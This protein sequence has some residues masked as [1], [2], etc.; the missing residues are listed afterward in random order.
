MKNKLNIIGGLMVAVGIAVFLAGFWCVGSDFRKITTEPPYT[1]KTFTAAAP[2]TAI[3]VHDT[4]TD[5]EIVAADVDA[6]RISYE[7]NEKKFYEISESAGT[8]TVEKRSNLQWY[9]YIFNIRFVSPILKI[10]VPRT[11]LESLEVE[12]TSGDVVA[13]GIEAQLVRLVSQ[14]STVRGA[15]IVCSGEVYAANRNGRI[16]LENVTA[17]DALFCSTTN[18]T[19]FLQAVSAAAVHI[20]NRNGSIALLDIASAGDID[21]VSSNDNIRLE[22]VDFAGALTCDVR[23]GGIFGSVRGSVG[24]FSFNC[25]AENGACNLPDV[26]AAGEKQIHLRASNDD[27]EVQFVS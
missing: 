2:C 8:L 27:I 18:D 26:L 21:A 10:E 9:D 5:V 19:V 3:L 16:Q 12:T 15:D 7:E 22:R 6:V 25:K 14:N 1:K 20:E 24:D 23:N 4:G 11:L 13:E 17:G